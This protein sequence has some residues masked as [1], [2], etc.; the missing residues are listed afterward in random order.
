MMK[1]CAVFFILTVTFY[2]QCRGPRSASSVPDDIYDVM[3]KIVQGINVTQFI[4]VI[5]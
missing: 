1:S 2:V 5:G 4:V 3:L